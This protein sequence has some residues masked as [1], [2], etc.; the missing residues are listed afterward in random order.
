[1]C[2][3]MRNILIVSIAMSGLFL[4]AVCHGAKASTATV[5]SPKAAVTNTVALAQAMLPSST[6]RMPTQT[7]LPSS[8]SPMPTRTST[9]TVSPT[10]KPTQ[11][12]T[13]TLTPQPTGTLKPTVIF[14]PLP[15]SSLAEVLLPTP[16]ALNVSTYQL[17]PWIEA[18][19]LALTDRVNRGKIVASPEPG[20]D[21]IKDYVLAFNAEFFMRFPQSSSW[22]DIAWE[23]T[24]LNPHGIPVAGMRAGEDLFAFLV[25]N[26]LNNQGTNIE[27]L[28]SRLEPHLFR[29][30]EIIKIN[31]LF[32]DG[33]DAWVIH[34]RT[35]YYQTYNGIYAI[36][37]VNGIYR[38]EVIYDWIG[39]SVPGVGED[40]SLAAVG[41]T[42]NNGIQE[43]GIIVDSW[44]DGVMSALPFKWGET[45]MLYEWQPS[46]DA[47]SSNG[48]PIYDQ[49][50]N[51]WGQGPC[52]GDWKFGDRRLTT[53][54]YWFTQGD[55]PNLDVQSLY[56]WDGTRYYLITV[57][58]PKLAIAP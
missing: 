20:F 48:F 10:R 14:T 40:Y 49:T 29:I 53:N 56:G 47:F 24:R 25:E 58:S 27:E 43:I 57:V 2:K 18:D 42:N 35:D 38:L 32:G 9:T 1:M 23:T 12:H 15:T 34:A 39:F 13:P 3:L 51:E 28:S 5:K 52:K 54:E 4:L 41:D 55:C 30:D 6:S 36:H 17:R 16:P 8:T 19:S 26:I 33:Q 11:T 44:I 37:K 21:Q 45:L 31:N 50:C 46:K 7:K 22:E